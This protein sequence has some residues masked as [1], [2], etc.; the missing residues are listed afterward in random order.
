MKQQKT[1]RH[2]APFADRKLN[3]MSAYHTHRVL[4]RVVVLLALSCLAL[5]LPA[6]DNNRTNTNTDQ[7]K[8]TTNNR[9]SL[10]RSRKSGD[11]PQT[12]TRSRRDQAERDKA[13]ARNSNQPGS[14]GAKAA[15]TP[16]P[17]QRTVKG[18][19]APERKAEGGGARPTTTV[20]FKMK[21]DQSANLL[22]ME[23]IGVAPT[24]NIV[25]QQGEDFATRV[26]FANPR[27]SKFT[28]VDVAMRFEPSVVELTGID[29]ADIARLLAVPAIA[30][31]DARRG[32]FSYH[33]EFSQPQDRE[34]TVLFKLQWKA[35][36][37][38]DFSPIAFL[39]TE[40]FPSR[41][42]NQAQNVLIRTSDDDDVTGDIS[43]TGLIDAALSVS[44]N[45]ESVLDMQD[46]GRGDSSAM[47]LAHQISEGTAVGGV[48]LALRPR[49]GAVRVGDEFLVDIVYSNPRRADI[50]SVRVK[51]RFDPALLQVVDY[52]TDNWITNG[53]NILDGPYHD[54]LPF[55]FHIRNRAYNNTGM[56]LYE[57]GFAYKARVPTSGIIAT[58]RFRAMAATAAADILFDTE[59]TARSSRTAVS[60]LGFN[61]VG[62][63]ADRESALTNATVSVN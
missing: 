30:K 19:A 11:N 45:A 29:D 56:I 23:S 16:A 7:K 58:I 10:L 5:P 39:N 13:R 57:K 21:A 46:F 12:E 26:V 60:F 25:A 18:S 59:E 4:R 62:S 54:D 43:N 33:A 1:L 44:P 52:D 34:L 15:A 36:M 40:D 2:E 47:V 55:D 63:P 22:F 14:A 35:K 17:G 28:S 42:L 8:S 37:P 3:V 38:A 49:T 41:V 51:V 50:D 32:V 53:V 6:Q 20:E 48:T 31:V 9:P 27:K 61:L 24:M